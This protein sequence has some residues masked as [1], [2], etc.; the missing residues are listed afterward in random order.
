[1]K[2]VRFISMVALAGTLMT[3]PLTKGMAQVNEASASTSAEMAKPVS[4]HV[5]QTKPM[6]FRVLYNT[7]QSS[8]IVVRIL[9]SNG[10][11]LFNESRNI[12]SGYLR[13][14]DLSTLA[15][16]TYT[17]ELVDG[18]EKYNQ[19]YDILTQ[20]RRIVSSIK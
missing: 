19:S 13:Y 1:M 9:A 15:D 18:Q 4:F 2:T 12:E 6:Q 8:K 14:F 16:G 5:V 20:T 3:A 17:F 7:P 10:D 11:V